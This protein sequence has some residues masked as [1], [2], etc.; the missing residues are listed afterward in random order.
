M[1]VLKGFEA[2]QYVVIRA[3][4]IVAVGAASV[5]VDNSG[6]VWTS[7]NGC[8]RDELRPRVEYGNS[9]PYFFKVYP[10]V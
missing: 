4:D 10:G 7:H 5:Y 2:A 1:S 6:F 9:S 3:E 8:S